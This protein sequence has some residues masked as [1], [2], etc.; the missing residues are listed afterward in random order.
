MIYLTGDIHGKLDKIEYYCEKYNTTKND[1][2]IILGDTGFNYYLNGRDDKLKQ[3]ASKLPVTLFCIRGNH[4]ERPENTGKYE[5]IEFQD[6]TAYIEHKYPNIIFAKDGEMYIMNGEKVLC[7]GGAYSVD[8]YYRIVNG[9]QWFSG[10]QLS[11][12]EMK[13]IED[14]ILDYLDWFGT[15]DYICTHTCPYNTRPL[16][17]FLPDIDQSKV[18]NSMEMW[19]Q[20]LANIIDFKRWYFGHFHGDWTNGKYTMLY[21]ELI[22]LG[23]S[24]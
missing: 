16:H 17:L 24:I 18:D 20:E 14:D 7:I 19:L 13:V 15:F 3:K 22:P 10:E 4:E 9:Y 12:D 6:G 2:I 8:K 1:I 21:N 11:L 5:E 23:E